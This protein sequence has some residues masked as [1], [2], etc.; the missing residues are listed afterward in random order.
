[1]TN[2]AFSHYAK[3]ISH[4]RTDAGKSKYPSSTRY[5]APHKPFLLLTILD[6]FDQGVIAAN[7]VPLSPDLADMFASYWQLLM[8]SDRTGYLYMPFFHMKNDG[9]W[10]LSPQPG[11]EA[12]LNAIRQIGG[13]KQL[14]DTVLG[15]QFDSDLYKLLCVKENRDALRAIIIETYFST[16]AHGLLLEQT[17]R[18]VLA[19]EYSIE[20]LEKARRHIAP[21]IQQADE[22]ERPV[23]DQ[24]FRKA[25]VIAYD[26]RCVMCGVRLVTYEGRTVAEAAHIVPWSVSYNDDP[27]NGLCLCRVCHWAFDVGLA[28]ITP[29]YRIR[30]SE[31][32]NT[33]GNRP[34]HLSTLEDRPIFEPVEG[35]YSP[36]VDS[37][38]WHIKNIFLR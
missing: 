8:P 29:K 30:L 19:H 10:H 23:R 11:N 14:R 17:N 38:K 32:I 2:D 16:D 18:N 15:G 33:D 35:I 20:L 9:F 36:Y 25:I 31:Q 4:L 34:G 7:F 1:M 12:V 6:L 28:G 37:L 27:R 21:S 5:R 22:D 13:A 26:H 24:G 3:L